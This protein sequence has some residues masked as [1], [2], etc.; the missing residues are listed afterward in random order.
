LEVYAG[1]N[2]RDDAQRSR[3][4]STNHR[5]ARVLPSVNTEIKI[6]ALILQGYLDSRQGV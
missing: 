3:R 6:L 1:E 4:E 2:Q 5:Q